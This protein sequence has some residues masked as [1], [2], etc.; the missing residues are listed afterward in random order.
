MQCADNPLASEMLV[1][2][3]GTV[4]LSLGSEIEK[5]LTA[6]RGIRSPRRSCVRIWGDNMRLNIYPGPSS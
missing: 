1:F 2:L 3:L 5:W 4:E 6:P